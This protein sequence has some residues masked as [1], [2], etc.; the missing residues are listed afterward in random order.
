[1]RRGLLAIALLCSAVS[2]PTSAQDGCQPDAQ[3]RFKKPNVLV[4]LDYSSSMRGFEQAPAYFPAG[5]TLS[6]RWDAQ[7]DATAWILRYDGGFFSDNARIGL[8]RFAHDPHLDMPGTVLATDLSFPPITDGF[9]LDLP[10]DGSD[11]TYLE[12]K[13]SAVEAEVAVL[14]TTPP[15]FI[16][17]EFDVERMM[18]TWT[19]GALASAHAVVRQTRVRHQHEPGEDERSYEVVLMTDG[20]WTCPDMIGQ[21][22]NEDPADQAALLRADG[23]RVHVVAFGDAAMVPSLD[24]VA[25]QGG[26]AASIDATSP[27]GIIDALSSV[28]DDIRNSVIVPE[29][30]AGLPRV[31]LIMD[32]SSSMIDGTAPGTTKWDKARFALTGNPQ[33]PNPSDPG[34]VEPIF[35]RQLDLDG[36]TVAIEDVVHLGLMTFSDA[37][38]QVLLAGFA[39]CMR[40]NFAWAMDPATSCVAPGCSDPY[41]G[42][43]I[44]WSFQ[45]SENLQTPLVRPTQSF[46]PACNQSPDGGCQGQTP[47]TFTGQGLEFA[48]QVIADYRKNPSPFHADSATRYVNILITDGQTSQGSSDVQAALTALVTEGVETHVIG[49]GSDTELDV[50]QLEQY[51]TWGNTSAAIVVDPDQGDSANALAAALAGVVA[52]IGLDACCV[53]NDCS[54]QPE[55]QDPAPLCGD[56]RVE[57][58]ELCD[59]G[60]LNATYGHCAARCDGLHLYCGDG[61]VDGD[62]GCDD[63]NGE[64]GDGCSAVCQRE[65]ADEDGGMG[66]AANGVVTPRPN[67]PPQGPPQLIARPAVDGGLDAGP[68]GDS[69]AADGCGCATIGA[70]KTAATRTHYPW[71]V[72]G[73]AITARRRQRVRAQRLNGRWREYHQ[74]SPAA[75]AAPGT[76]RRPRSP[77]TRSAPRGRPQS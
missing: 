28:L 45:S 8:A 70:P 10:F 32:G 34:Y 76:R 61:R 63:G 77:Q 41:A 62:E 58:G 54:E 65:D 55:P 60:A 17:N 4:L 75:S 68:T 24:E 16:T 42:F 1:M 71:L 15:P 37:D 12:C 44:E 66:A 21:G 43:P 5:Q 74:G 3:C 14:R 35:S 64:D 7:L 33:A 6:T 31:L 18:L 13:G 67:I 47:N 73:L 40:D 22:C 23:I 56:G 49:F 57:G 59:D 50:A 36:R 27:E 52:E 20:D 25:L 9:A 2:S 39:P 11:G 72:L 51:A 48:R 29:C 53:L 38:T 19:R 46:M 30:T 69:N 26:T